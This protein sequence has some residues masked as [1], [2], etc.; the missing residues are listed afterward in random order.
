MHPQLDSQVVFHVMMINL[1]LVIL[2]QIVQLV[3][4]QIVLKLHVFLVPLVI[5]VLLPTTLCYALMDIFDFRKEFQD[6]NG[7]QLF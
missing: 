3:R 6:L 4:Y 7:V 2:V 1:F 5:H